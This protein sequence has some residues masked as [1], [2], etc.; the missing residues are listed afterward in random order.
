MKIRDIFLEQ[1]EY[2]QDDFKKSIIYL[3]HTAGSYRPDYVVHGWN[4]D[5][6]ADGSIRK[7]ATAF[8][9]GGESSKYDN[10]WDGIIVRAFP[11]SKWAWHLGAKGTNGLYDKLSIGVE[12]C[13]FGYLNKS[14]NGEYMTYINKPLPKDQV[15]ELDTPFRGYRYY[16][17]YTDR[18]IDNLRELLLYLG[19]KFDINLKLGLQ[20]W[21]NKENLILPNNLS[22]LEQQKWLNRH[23]FIGQNGLVLV[24]DGLWGN[25]TSFAIQSIGKSAFEFN[26]LTLNG[27]SGIWSHSN[28]RKDKFDCNPQPNLIN[29]LKTL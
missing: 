7:I 5:S 28:I 29:M 14:K 13:N 8:V 24:E 17:K 27:H 3:H 10:S 20:E 12:L 15:V 2:F 21:I 6:N 23:G 9:I 25:N 11:E 16:H 26:P 4:K 18:Q 1:D 22:I 19:C